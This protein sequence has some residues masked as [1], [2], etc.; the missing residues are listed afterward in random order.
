MRSRSRPARL[1]T[2]LAA[3]GGIGIVASMLFAFVIADHSS[4]DSSPSS[5]IAIGLGSIGVVL[6]VLGCAVF[7][8]VAVGW[9]WRRAGRLSHR[10]SGS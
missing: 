3:A 4:S 2:A 7:T 5:V 1:A 10:G 9:L 6:V 8:G